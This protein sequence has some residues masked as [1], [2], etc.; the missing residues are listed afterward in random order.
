M[1]KPTRNVP[2]AREAGARVDERSGAKSE[3]REVGQLARRCDRVGSV[4]D[5][6][7]D[8]QQGERGGRGE[9]PR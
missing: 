1:Q 8:D 7:R 6:A 5:R 3:D 2:S 4:R 9:Q